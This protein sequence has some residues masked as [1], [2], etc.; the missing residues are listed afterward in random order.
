MR[1]I[2]QVLVITILASIMELFLPWWSIALAAA[3][4]GYLFSTGANFL[5]GFLSIVILWVITSITIDLTAGAALTEKVAAIFSTTK[6][7]LFVITALI[8]GLVGGF[9]A[10][11]GGALRKDR[12]RMKYY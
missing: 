10:M 11:A 1:F 4:G 3:V 6:P 8:G 12:R 9:A 5:A 2:I 7:V